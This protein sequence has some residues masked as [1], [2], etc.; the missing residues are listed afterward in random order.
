MTLD[1]EW[2]FSTI[3]KVKGEIEECYICRKKKRLEYY[4]TITNTESRVITGHQKLCKDCAVR[5]TI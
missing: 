5:L 3:E 2:Y 1:N 4:R